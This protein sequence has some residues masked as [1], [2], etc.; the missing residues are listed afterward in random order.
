MEFSMSQ[1]PLS[2]VRLD[3]HKLIDTLPSSATWD[4]VMYRIYVR[5]SIEAGLTDVVAGNTVPVAQVRR[6]FGL[7]K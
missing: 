6:D 2:D 5:Q 4:D 3:A 7:D 1:A